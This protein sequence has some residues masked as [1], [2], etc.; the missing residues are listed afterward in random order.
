MLD[1]IIAFGETFTES[2]PQFSMNWYYVAYLFAEL[3][4]VF[5]FFRRIIVRLEVTTKMQIYEKVFDLENVHLQAGRRFQLLRALPKC[6]KIFMVD[7]FR[8]F[9]RSEPPPP[10]RSPG[11]MKSTPWV[12]ILFLL[13]TKGGHWHDLLLLFFCTVC[14]CW[15]HYV[16]DVRES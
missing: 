15:T 4:C 14:H 10:W 8:C 6:S 2:L 11:A 7:D 9:W 1:D 16:K 5:E 3:I 13:W 12:V